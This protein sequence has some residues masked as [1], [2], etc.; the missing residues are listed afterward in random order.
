MG[1]I[2]VNDT[3]GESGEPDELAK[4]YFIDSEALNKVL[5]IMNRI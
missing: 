4:K 1:F 2:G 5:K 3:F